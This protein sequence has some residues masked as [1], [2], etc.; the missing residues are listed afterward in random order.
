[1]YATHTRL[2]GTV[3]FDLQVLLAWFMLGCCEEGQLPDCDEL[4]PCR[5]GLVLAILLAIQSVVSRFTV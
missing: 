1:M 2:G 5:P 4:D 3:G